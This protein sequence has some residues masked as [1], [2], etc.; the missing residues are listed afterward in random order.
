[1]LFEVLWG[2]LAIDRFRQGRWKRELFSEQT[3]TANRRELHHGDFCSPLFLLPNSKLRPR[4]R[5]QCG[6][7]APV[8]R[9][10]HFDASGRV[11]VAE[12]TFRIEA[13]RRT[14]RPSGRAGLSGDQCP[15]AGLRKPNESIHL[16]ARPSAACRKQWAATGRSGRDCCHSEINGP[17]IAC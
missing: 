8:V 12:C 14:G 4:R 17:L 7:S 13:N 9:R 3:I 16:H 11:F 2:V 15:L 1:M 6:L 5:M 10:T